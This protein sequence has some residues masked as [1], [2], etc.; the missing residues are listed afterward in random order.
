MVFI[1]YSGRWDLAGASRK[2]AS[3]MFQPPWLFRRK[4]NPPPRSQRLLHTEDGRFRRV[5]VALATAVAFAAAMELTAQISAPAPYGGWAFRQSAGGTLQPPWLFL[6]KRNPTF[7]A[8]RA[9]GIQKLTEK[10]SNQQNF[11]PR[12]KF[13]FYHVNHRKSREKVRY[14]NDL[15]CFSRFEIFQKNL[16]K[17]VDIWHPHGYN[18]SCR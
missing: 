1:F 11:S 5:P 7:S 10:N 6:E 9:G 18:N 16:K 13:S 17:G 8:G 2:Y 3:G 4:A 12:G 15:V 14:F